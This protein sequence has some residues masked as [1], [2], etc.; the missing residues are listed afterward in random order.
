[1]IQRN[2]IFGWAVFGLS[3]LV[4]SYLIV[5]QLSRYTRNPSRLSLERT[6]EEE[7]GNPLTRLT[8]LTRLA[9]KA[10]NGYTSELFL[11]RVRRAFMT[12]IRLSLDLSPAEMRKIIS[13]RQALNALTVDDDLRNLLSGT[14]A[15]QARSKPINVE[16][17]VSKMEAWTHEDR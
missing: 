14:L 4:F 7:E 11:D 16:L 13:D 17:L 15:L 10:D 6:A 5:D 8:E 9:T 3:F 12:K 2:E 1:M